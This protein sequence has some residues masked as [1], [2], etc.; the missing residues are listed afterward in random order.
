M[1]EEI[2]EFRNTRFYI[3][4]ITNFGKI[5]KTFKRTGKTTEVMPKQLNNYKYIN[6]CNKDGSHEFIGVHRIVAKAFCE[7]PEGY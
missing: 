6:F 3:W 2:K 5:F 7:V 4:T 1:K